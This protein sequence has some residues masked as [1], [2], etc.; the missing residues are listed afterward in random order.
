MV[1]FHFMEN[2]ALVELSINHRTNS[3]GPKYGFCQ[4]GIEKDSIH[5]KWKDLPFFKWW[6]FQYSKIDDTYSILNIDN[7]RV[8]FNYEATV[9]SLD[10]WGGQVAIETKYL[11][12]FTGKLCLRCNSSCNQTCISGTVARSVKW[13]PM[14]KII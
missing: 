5:Y 10:G 14:G 8:F 2:Y 12:P 13:Y 1:I 7:N 3:F 6:V 11:K 9:Y 4:W